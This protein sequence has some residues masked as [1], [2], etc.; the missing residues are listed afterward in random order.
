MAKKRSSG[1]RDLVKSR[2]GKSY[3]KRTAKGRF[4]EMDSVKR[5]SKT[6][7]RTKAKKKVKAGFGDKGDRQSR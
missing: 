2:T 1:K 6:D 4:R 7:R 3:A 5:S